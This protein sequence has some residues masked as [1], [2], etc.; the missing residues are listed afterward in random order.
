MKI[1]I[2]GGSGVISTSVA[3][4]LIDR[5]EKPTLLNRGQ[6]PVRLR[7]DFEHL[8]ADRTDRRAFEDVVRQSGPWDAVVDMTCSN[9]DD[10]ASLAG[11]IRGRVGQLVFC[12]TTNVYPKPADAYPVPEDHRLGAAYKNGIDKARCE[13]IHHDAETAGDY[14]VTII[15]PGHTYGETGGVL[16]CMASP[17]FID[18]MRRG[19][20]MVVHGD[21]QGLWSA[22]HADDVA[23]V[24]AAATG[25]TDAFGRVYNATGT[26]WM[27]WNQYHAGIAG[28][29]GVEP[30]EFIHIPTHVLALLAPARTAQC[31]RSLQYPGIYDMSAARDE[32]GFHARVPFVKGMRRVIDWL[33]AHDRIEPWDSDPD[34]DRIIQGWKEC[35]AA[36]TPNQ[37]GKS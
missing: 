13:A 5:G 32:L 2:I 15:R 30:P 10:A 31:K 8:T 23:R 14:R 3:Q 18:R 9:P 1:L 29:L 12:S 4:A 6:T 21:G 26:E 25:N 19:K 28:A 11:A 36:I 24:F 17:A 20:P 35:I 7:G 34:Y 22:L 16:N 33:D 27:T 37:G